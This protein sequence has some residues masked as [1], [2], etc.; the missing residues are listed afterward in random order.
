MNITFE[1]TQLVGSQQY[2]D[3]VAFHGKGNGDVF[4]Q[5][6]LVPFFL[7][8]MNV[9][10]AHPE[11]TTFSLYTPTSQICA[12]SADGIKGRSAKSQHQHNSFEFTYVL[13]G[14][15]YQIVE[16][17]RYYYPTG[18]CCLMNR[19][20]LHTEEFSSDYTCLFLSISPGFVQKLMNNGQPLLF[21][22][23][24]KLYQNL[25]FR[26]LQQNMDDSATDR[27]DFLDFVPKI[28]QNEQVAL[29]HQIFEDLL[30]TIITP[31]YGASF[32]LLELLSRLIGVLGDPEYYNGEHVT[33]QSNV[34]SLLFSRIERIL[35]ER[36]GRVTN[37]Q[38]AEL[39]SYNG[40]YLGRI[41]KKYTGKSLF[42]YSMT[43]TM[44]YFRSQLLTT[45]KTTA[46]IAAEL[47]FTNLTHLYGLFKKHFGTTPKEYRKLHGGRPLKKPVN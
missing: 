35:S 7:M 42:D 8:L 31:S 34:E 29:V 15:M 19:N 41:V 20:T 3:I 25:I 10:A 46:E 23:E 30:Y 24:Q 21:A 47:H 4:V 27:K 22:D 2:K 40:S 9:Q 12:I 45:R 36:H 11:K 17:K 6:S 5:E 43:F 14:D 1:P 33:A 39:L 13:E 26:F 28:T 16:G 38:L 18:S 37:A 32:R 44:E